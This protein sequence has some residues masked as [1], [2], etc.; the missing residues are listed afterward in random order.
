MSKFIIKDDHVLNQKRKILNS[1]NGTGK[2][3]LVITNGLFIIYISVTAHFNHTNGLIMLIPVLKVLCQRKGQTE[4]NKYRKVII[5]LCCL[6]A[7]NVSQ[8]KKFQHSIAKKV[9]EEIIYFL[10]YRKPVG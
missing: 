8:Q 9:C 2:I 6:K 10:H 5:W 7:F 4:V 1:E 3:Y